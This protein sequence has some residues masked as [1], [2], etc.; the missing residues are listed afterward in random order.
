MIRGWEFR[1][2]ES[3]RWSSKVMIKLKHNILLFRL[4]VEKN[5]DESYNHSEYGSDDNETGN[6]PQIFLAKVDV[7]T[8][9]IGFKHAP[10]K[11]R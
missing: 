8:S 10:L 4:D 2:C 1:I 7:K 9:S 6:E 11:L 3:I 5:N